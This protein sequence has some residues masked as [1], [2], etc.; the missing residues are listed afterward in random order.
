M[1]RF[2]LRT[3][4][5][6]AAGAAMLTAPGCGLFQRDDK[7]QQQLQDCQNE[8]QKVQ[9]QRDELQQFT[10]DQQKQIRSLQNLGDKRLEKLYHVKTIEIGRYTAGVDNDPRP[11]DDAVKVFIRPLDQ[12]GDVVKAAG[13]MTIQIFDLSLAPKDT[14]IALCQYKVDE[15]SKYWAS[16]FLTYHYSFECKWKTPPRSTDVTVRAEFVDYLTG[17]H[18]VAQTVAKVKLAPPKTAT[19]PAK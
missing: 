3:A 12:N 13:D 10:L 14:L 7:L 6:A 8:L 19:K 2:P 17:K 9:L 15:L 11:G 4:L 1:I 16:G 18:H 5:L